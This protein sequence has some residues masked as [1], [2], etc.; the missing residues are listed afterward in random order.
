[1]F[2]FS[3]YSTGFLL[4]FGAGFV[5]RDLISNGPSMLR[6]LVKGVMKMGVTVLEKTRDTIAQMVESA[7]D[8]MA[9]VRSEQRSKQAQSEV[10]VVSPANAS[11]A[12]KAKT[13]THSS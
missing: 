12:K 5:S 2:Q 9:E 8:L 6:P 7:E 4:G 11:G 1:M 13:A 3:K 10:S